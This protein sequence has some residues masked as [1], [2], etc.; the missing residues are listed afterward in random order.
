MNRIIRTLLMAVIPLSFLHAAES[1]V[2]DGDTKVTYSRYVDN[3]TLGST[4]TAVNLS[5]FSATKLAE[6]F[7]A[8]PGIFTLTKAILSIDGTVYGTVW[9]QNNDSESRSAT[10]TFNVTGGNSKLTFGG[11]STPIQY[12]ND[13]VEIG[14]VAA[15]QRIDTSVSVTGS[16]GAVTKSYITD[17]LAAF[18]GNGDITTSAT[19]KGAGAFYVEGISASTSGFDLYGAANVSVTYEYVPEPST[20]ALLGFGC[21]ALLTRR[22]SKRHLC[23]AQAPSSIQA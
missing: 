4:P 1:V 16:G 5:Q 8:D 7:S 6:H 17:A 9:F 12:F 20:L 22:R 15:G 19:L 18:I 14:S 11:Q 23:S 3:L 2:W 13:G 10:P 21:A